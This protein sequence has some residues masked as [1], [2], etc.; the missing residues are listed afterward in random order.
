[1]VAV[2]ALFIHAS[3]T[4][5]SPIADFRSLMTGKAA[6]LSAGTLYAPGQAGNPQAA[7]GSSVTGGLINGA[8]GS[9]GLPGGTT[10][11]PGSLTYS[12]PTGNTT[13]GL[14]GLTA[15]EYPNGVPKG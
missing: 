3:L 12:G 13:G 2:G 1:M 6:G 5:Q 7:P 4:N 11:G 14:A 8:P 15:G 10:S 9:G